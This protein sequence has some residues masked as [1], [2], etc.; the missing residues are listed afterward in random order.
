MNLI[1]AVLVDAFASVSATEEAAT[2]CYHAAD[3]HVLFTSSPLQPRT[4]PL[5]QWL[6]SSCVDDGCPASVLQM[7]QM[8]Q[9]YGLLLCSVTLFA[10]YCLAH[11][12]RYMMRT[13]TQ[14]DVKRWCELPQV[15]PQVYRGV[16]R[17][18]SIIVARVA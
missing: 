18:V 17:P 6:M 15:Y 2:V 16:P 11:I 8:T 3:G 5:R 7:R 14:P 10:L 1:R 12:M 9:T 13:C 4:E